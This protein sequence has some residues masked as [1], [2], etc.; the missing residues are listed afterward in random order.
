MQGLEFL[1]NQAYNYCNKSNAFGNL[2]VTVME[3]GVSICDKIHKN[4]F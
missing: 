4:L 2:R 1:P 3:K